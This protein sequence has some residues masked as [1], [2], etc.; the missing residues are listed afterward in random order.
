MVVLRSVLCLSFIVL[1]TCYSCSLLCVCFNFWSTF[2]CGK[3]KEAH[4]CITVIWT[5]LPF[6][7]NIPLALWAPSCR[8]SHCTAAISYALFQPISRKIGFWVL[9]WIYFIERC[10]LS[11]LCCIQGLKSAC[12]KKCRLWRQLTD[13]LSKFQPDHFHFPPWFMVPWYPFSYKRN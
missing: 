12:L 6:F 13:F 9:P 5:W 11:N 10:F 3:A 1:C 4:F 2:G 7:P 8:H